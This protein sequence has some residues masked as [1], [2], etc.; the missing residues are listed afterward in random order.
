MVAI[1]AGVRDLTGVHYEPQAAGLHKSFLVSA[2]SISLVTHYLAAF[3]G[4]DLQVVDLAPRSLC[5]D[6]AGKPL[7]WFCLFQGRACLNFGL[8]CEPAV[9][10]PASGLLSASATEIVS[11][12]FH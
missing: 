2:I 4:R 10:Y 5:H 11:V 3:V 9:C 8:N 1:Q 6:Q 12:W 7:S